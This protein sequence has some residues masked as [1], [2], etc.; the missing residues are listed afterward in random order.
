MA[1]V[2]A[3]RLAQRCVG[4]G[5]VEDV[6]DDLEQD[7]EL[8]SVAPIG[9]FGRANDPVRQQDAPDRGADQ[10]AGLERVDGA[11]GVRGRRRVG[12]IQEL[13]R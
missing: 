8:R 3:L 12:D 5:H 11:E 10:A 1:L 13:D 6:V 7:A 9:L 4:A 2:A